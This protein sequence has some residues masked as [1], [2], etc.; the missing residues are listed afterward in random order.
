M[1]GDQRVP[2]Q[3][4]F[5]DITILKIRAQF[6]NNIDNCVDC[7]RIY[8]LLAVSMD[9]IACN[10]RCKGQTDSQSVDNRIFFWVGGYVK[11][12]G[13]E[14][15][16]VFVVNCYRFLAFRLGP[17]PCSCSQKTMENVSSIRSS[18]TVLTIRKG[19]SV[20]Y[21]YQRDNGCAERTNLEWFP[22]LQK[23][24]LVPYPAELRRS[25]NSLSLVCRVI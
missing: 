5:D 20:E 8:S 10:S 9:C 6:S 7:C 21:W 2:N 22:T 13:C 17:M 24:Q 14:S 3:Q 12:G 15:V 23:K 25:A 19:R 4:F 1:A 16:I 11:L 18:R